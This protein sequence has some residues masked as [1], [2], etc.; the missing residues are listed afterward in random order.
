MDEEFREM[1]NILT[2]VFMVLVH[3]VFSQHINMD[4]Y[5]KIVDSDF[6]TFVDL[7][8]EESI[9]ISTE[10]IFSSKILNNL[11]K[12]LP[13][14]LVDKFLKRD[15]KFLFLPLFIDEYENGTNSEVYGYFTPLF[16]LPTNGDYALLVFLQNDYA[17]DFSK[18]VRIMS[19][20]L[21][22][23][24]ITSLGSGWFIND[25]AG[26]IGCEL[27]EELKIKYSYLYPA[28]EGD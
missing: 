14:D 11:G 9:P 4:A 19:F 18:I 27:D 1:K 28:L 12:E 10:S 2:F 22:G 6:E 8:D 3:T 25:G 13:D 23:E 21:N 20:D 16:K 26:Y 17:S 5:D 15:Q 7:F 24:F